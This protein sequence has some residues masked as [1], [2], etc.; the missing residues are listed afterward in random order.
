MK[1]DPGS[2]SVP[3]EV[4]QELRRYA[5]DMMQQMIES[6]SLHRRPV[7]GLLRRLPRRPA[8]GGAGRASAATSAGNR[9]SKKYFRKNFDQ[10]TMNFS[11]DL[12]Q[13]A[14]VE[15]KINPQTTLEVFFRGKSAE[16]LKRFVRKIRLDS[17]FF[18]NLDLTVKVFGDFA[19]SNLEAVGGR[20]EIRR[21]SI[22]TASGA[23]PRAHPDLHRRAGADLVAVADRRQ[24]RGRVPRPHQARRARLGPVLRAEAHGV[25]RDQHRGRLPGQWCSARSPPARSTSRR[26]SCRAS[27]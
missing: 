14:V 10:L 4:L 24:P 22:S 27:R 16:E 20:A 21:R 2:A 12:Q 9:N 23:T 6:R 5:L 13:H 3:D 15:W 11:L 19:G 25:E 7:G 17:P 1:I 8:R 18:E 26:S